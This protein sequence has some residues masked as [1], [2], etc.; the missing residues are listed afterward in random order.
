MISFPEALKLLSEN[1]QPLDTERVRIEDAAGR[2]LRDGVRADRPFPPFDRVM[3]DGYALRL[4][5]WRMG[6]RQYRVTAAAPAGQPA[7]ALNPAPATCVEVMTGAPL[8]AGADLIV[9][10]EETSTLAP[11]LILVS[12]AAELVSGRHIHRSGNDAK[13][14]E[15]VLAPGIMLD[16]R[17]LGAAASC[18]A[19]WLTVSRLPRIAIFATGDEL[20]PVD[21][22]PLPHQIRQSNAH[23]IRA[24]LQHAGYPVAISGTLPD[25]PETT[26]ASL[27][28]ALAT[29]DWLI[30][31]GAISMGA[32]DFIPGILVR[33]GCRRLFHGIAQRPGKPAGCWLGPAG[34][35]IAALPGNPVS[36]ITGLHALVLP[37][38]AAASGLK[39]RPPRH[40]APASPLK[41]L[42]AFTHHLPV[43]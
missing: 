28:A 27:T 26:A 31:T 4:A 13:A 19:A 41:I 7:P 15:T 29:H 3:M 43:T 40:L 25:E 39:P 21:E 5:D 11:G 30:L 36:A 12:P 34:Q 20:V 18:G 37:A 17:H 32:R 14:G 24:A 22:T 38:L 35:V 23:S 8:P 2:I 6:A 16:S 9:P 10:V 42:P 1:T 33:I